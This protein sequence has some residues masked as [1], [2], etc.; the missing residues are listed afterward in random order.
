MP[1][2]GETISF[3][4]VFYRTSTGAPFV[5]SST[6]TAFIIEPDG[7]VAV[8]GSNMTQQ[9]SSVVWAYDYVPDVAGEHVFY[10]HTADSNAM[11]DGY[12]EVE[13][14]NVGETVRVGSIA[15]GAIDADAIAADA[16]T[17][18]QSGLATSAA[19]AAVQA[20]TDDIQTRLP[21]ALVSGRID[22]SVGAMASGVVTAAALATG[23]ID[24]DA[25]AADA[26]GEIADGVWDEA[27]AGHL[28][29]GTTGKALS[30]ASAGGGDPLDNAVPGSYASGTAG[31]ALGLVDD[32]KAKTD[33]I[34]TGEITV[35]DPIADGGALIT[36]RRGETYSVAAGSALEWTV[37]EF[38]SVTGAT[39]TFQMRQKGKTTTVL[40]KSMTVVSSTVVRLE[41]TAAETA[42]LVARDRGYDYDI[43][44][45]LAASAGTRIVHGDV[46]VLDSIGAA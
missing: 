42:A 31:F 28:T 18:I 22:A 4:A 15:D 32:I 2:I 6:P 17:E 13:S 40:T 44:V 7:T 27:I 9:G 11:G 19:V 38:P 35:T 10:A 43:D 14:V 33:L 25:L 30:D 36:L 34:V 20:D 46:T 37:S 3:R 5:P 23:A 26:V 16:V 1:Q 45:A 29:A 41:L 39:V 21:A 8:N 24:A 12:T